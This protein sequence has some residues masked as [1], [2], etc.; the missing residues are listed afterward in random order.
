MTTPRLASR[1]STSRKLRENRWYSQTPWLRS[2]EGTGSRDTYFRWVSS[3]ESAESRLKLTVPFAVVNSMDH[4]HL[5]AKSRPGAT[6]G[7]RHPTGAV[8]SE[9][10][11]I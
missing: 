6:L 5:T 7:L 11:L 1:S 10:P 3:S 8:L 2:R 4:G 9:R